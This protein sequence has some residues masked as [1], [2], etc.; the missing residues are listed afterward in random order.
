MIDY[1]L[2]KMLLYNNG[3]VRLVSKTGITMTI[4]KEKD[5]YVLYGDNYG[6]M[7]GRQVNTLI[8]LA[9]THLKDIY[10]VV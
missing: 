2:I 4:D 10:K 1:D 8:K 3:H 5:K 7:T 9:I 6:T